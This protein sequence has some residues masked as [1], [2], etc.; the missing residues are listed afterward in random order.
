M[1]EQNRKEE[2]KKLMRFLGNIFENFSL[3]KQ[4]ELSDFESPS[5]QEHH[6]NRHLN[7]V[8]IIGFHNNSSSNNNSDQKDE[9]SPSISN[10]NLPYLKNNVINN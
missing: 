8:K 3:E 5:P 6:C 2:M 4:S 1:L 9:S 7:E 10:F